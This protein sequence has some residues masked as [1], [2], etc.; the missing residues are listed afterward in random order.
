MA[1]LITI[2]LILYGLSPVSAGDINLSDR[3]S[4]VPEWG[5]GK[6]LYAL[7]HDGVIENFFSNLNQ[8]SE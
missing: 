8:K 1:L 7:M 5:K 6:H 4:P 2:S 3:R